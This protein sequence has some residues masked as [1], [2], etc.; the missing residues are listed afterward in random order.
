MHYAQLVVIISFKSELVIEIQLAKSIVQCFDMV[1][2][3]TH[4]VYN[5]KSI[6]ILMDYSLVVKVCIRSRYF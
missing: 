3:C 5:T 6:I 1:Y 4:F 2:F